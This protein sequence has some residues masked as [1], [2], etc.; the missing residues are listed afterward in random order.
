MTRSVDG[1]AR[2]QHEHWAPDAE[3]AE[4]AA[5]CEAVVA[6]EHHVEED[7]VVRRR[8]RHPQRVFAPSRDVDR[9]S[10]LA[11][12]AG[13]HLGQLRFV[14]DDEDSHR[15]L[16]VLSLRETEMKAFIEPS[17]RSA[18][19]SRMETRARRLSATATVATPEGNS[20]ITAL[21]AA[22][23]LA[24]LALEGFTLVSLQTFISWHIVVGMLLVPIVLLK[25][26]STGYRF[27]RYYTGSREYVRA[28]P[29]PLP[30]RLLG[31]VVVLTTVA[32]FATGVALV[33]LGPSAPFV[34]LLHKASFAVWLAAMTVHVLAHVIRI[35]GLTAPDLRGGEGVPGSRLRLSL[36]AGA[37]VA[38]AIVAVATLPLVSPWAQ[39]VAH[40][41]GG[42]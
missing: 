15:I 14:F 2:R 16:I 35:P 6:G 24:L 20:R 37:V 11:E 38:G 18:F 9:V 32:L 13:E 36:V 29:P 5:G 42:G 23:L 4:P 17:S 31:P 8:L 7:R 10:L 27:A 34:L 12:P 22:V 19:V 40:G 28:G 33:A 21:T 30:L 39:W 1:V 3:L 41:G 26:A 25:V